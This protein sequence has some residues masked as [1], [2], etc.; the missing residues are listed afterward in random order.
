MFTVAKLRKKPR[1]FQS[2]TGLTPAQFQE[3]LDALRPAYEQAQRERLARE[4][5]QRAVGAG[6]KYTL[7][8]PERLLMGLVYWRL[9]VTQGLLSYLF[10]LDEANVSREISGRLRPLLLDVLPTPMRDGLLLGA[11]DRGAA[12]RGRGGQGRGGQGR[13]GQG[14][15]GQG[16][17]GQGRGASPQAGEEDRHPGRPAGG[18]PG[19]GRS[20]GRG[21]G[22]RGRHRAGSTQAKDEDAPGA[23]PSRR[24]KRLA[25]CATPASRSATP[26]RRRC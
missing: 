9:Y 16:R 12:D 3:L 6:R 17:G 18:L 10:G 21:G 1:H 20:A 7:A 25:R 14:R 8:L 23:T 26:S 24:A 11:A 5:R 19:G 2:F 22:L 13:G 4:D 15:G